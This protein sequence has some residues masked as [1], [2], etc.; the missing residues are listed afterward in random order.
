MQYFIGHAA[1]AQSNTT[2]RAICFMLLSRRND[3]TL[4]V[5]RHVH[6]SPL[7]GVIAA[8]VQRAYSALILT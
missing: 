7:G 4:P 6:T 2:H 8:M 3:V 5:W 1:T